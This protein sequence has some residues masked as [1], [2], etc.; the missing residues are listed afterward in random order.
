MSLTQK[1]IDRGWK[2]IVENHKNIKKLNIKVGLFGEGDSP[3]NN[4]AY[5]GLIHQEPSSS[6]KMPRR[7]FMSNAFDKNESNIKGFIDNEYRKVIDNKQNLKKMIDRIGV[8][9]EGDMK[10][11]FTQFDYIANKDATIQKKGSSRPLIA[12]AVM[13]NSIKYKVVS[14]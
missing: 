8:K 3:E 2:K 1:D 13:R 10:K 9:H 12:S 7:P 6:S 5:R 11:S 4:V 14:K